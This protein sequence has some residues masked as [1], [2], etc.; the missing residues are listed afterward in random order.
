MKRILLRSLLCGYYTWNSNFEDGFFNS[1]GVKAR[2][3]C[4]KLGLHN[5]TYDVP[6]RIPHFTSFYNLDAMFQ[7]LYDITI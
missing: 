6:N 2:S 7:I 5:M 1:S 3:D 4:V